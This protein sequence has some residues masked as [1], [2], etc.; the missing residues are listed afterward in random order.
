MGR[1]R[2]S[3]NKTERGSGKLKNSRT[4]SKEGGGRTRRSGE[5]IPDRYNGKSPNLSTDKEMEE[6]KDGRRRKR[7]AGRGGQRGQ[8]GRR[9][10]PACKKIDTTECFP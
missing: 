7:K 6:E 3:R 5:T 10:I 8:G 9:G 2:S 4:E 1:E